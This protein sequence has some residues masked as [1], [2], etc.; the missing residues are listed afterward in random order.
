MKNFRDIDDKDFERIWKNFKKK[1][2]ILDPAP[3][4]IISKLKDILMPFWINLINKVLKEGKFPDNLKHAVVS[5]VLKARYSDINDKLSYRPI[6]N[7]PFLAK[8][9]EKVV[10]E[11]INDYLEVNNLY[12]EMQS[13]YRKNYSCETAIY[14]I[15]KD[16]K[17]NLYQGRGTILILLDNSAAFDTIDHDI[18]IAFFT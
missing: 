6:S 3:I 11:E 10:L 16:V 13:S 18:L 14:S 15:I 4:W 7:T 17:A 12:S 1:S 2:C 9:I 8:M 5:P